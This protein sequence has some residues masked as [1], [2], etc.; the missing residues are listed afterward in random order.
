MCIC[1]IETH[2]KI[3]EAPFY[4]EISEQMRCPRTRIPIL[5]ESVQSKHMSRFG[6]DH[7]MRKFTGKKPPEW[8][9]RSSTGLYSY[10]KNPSGWTHGKG[11]NT[12]RKINN[13]Y[14]FQQE[15]QQK[16]KMLKRYPSKRPQT[17]WG[18][19]RVIYDII[20]QYWWWWYWRRRC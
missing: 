10:R 15:Q 7:L 6:K 19:G 13:K 9:P 11:I 8:A 2:V 18:S 12:R 4:M 16:Q 20:W 14:S 5:R 3:S 17:V 1:A